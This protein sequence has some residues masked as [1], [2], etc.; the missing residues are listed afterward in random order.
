[1]A[2]SSADGSRWQLKFDV[3]YRSIMSIADEAEDLAQLWGTQAGFVVNSQQVRSAD[4]R[5]C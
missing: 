2:G 4:L 5:L 1:L 3:Q